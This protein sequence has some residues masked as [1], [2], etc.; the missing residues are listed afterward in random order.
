M[1]FSIF[2]TLGSHL[3]RAICTGWV[4]A[5]DPL[6]ALDGVCRT[7]CVWPAAICGHV[8]GGLACASS[9]IPA[10]PNILILI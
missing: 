9:S 10:A 1:I 8:V 4:H 6:V 2:V 5:Y 3:D 7:V